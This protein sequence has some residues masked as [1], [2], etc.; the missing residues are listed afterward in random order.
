MK[1]NLC[2]SC[3]GSIDE[4]ARPGPNPNVCAACDAFSLEPEPETEDETEL[5]AWPELVGGLGEPW[6]WDIKEVA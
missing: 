3:G 1:P 6:A 4:T 2:Q 5:E